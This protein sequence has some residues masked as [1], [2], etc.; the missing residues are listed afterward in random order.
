MENFL[1]QYVIDT[2]RERHQCTM[3]NYI[4]NDFTDLNFHFRT[5][6]IQNASHCPICTNYFTGLQAIFKHFV[7]FHTSIR[8]YRCK[9]C[10]DRAYVSRF[11]VVKH[12]VD[13]H[14]VQ[15]PLENNN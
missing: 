2:S 4:A 9:L 11:H 1:K 10:N 8:P 5:T 6:H 7:V 3:C 13:G 14:G 15:I 12:I